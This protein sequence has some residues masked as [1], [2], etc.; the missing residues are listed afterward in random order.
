MESKI[1]EI[2]KSYLMTQLNE[3]TSTHM[4]NRAMLQ[5][6]KIVD[7]YTIRRSV[8]EVKDGL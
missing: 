3:Q 8:K 4:A 6:M 7:E 2:V 5:I 1:Q